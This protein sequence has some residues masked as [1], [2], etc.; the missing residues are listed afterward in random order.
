[1]VEDAGLEFNSLFDALLALTLL[2]LALLEVPS[3]AFVDFLVGYVTELLLLHL[4]LELIE[5]L[6]AAQVL[7]HT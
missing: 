7:L 4:V 1:L 6:P 5:Q 2:L 3:L